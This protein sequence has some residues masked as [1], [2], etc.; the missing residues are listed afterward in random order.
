MV[1]IGICKLI[2]LYFPISL[3][4]PLLSLPPVLRSDPPTRSAVSDSGQSRREKFRQ[5]KQ[6]EMEVDV[7]QNIMKFVE[8]FLR[9]PSIWVFENKEQ[10]LLIYEVRRKQLVCVR[11]WNYSQGSSP[12][13]VSVVGI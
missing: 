5:Q 4:S 1:E 8:D 2:H 13:R 7:M 6:K 9:N 3:S 11:G 12:K 10:N